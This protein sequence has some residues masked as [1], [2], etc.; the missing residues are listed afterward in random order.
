MMGRAMNGASTP[1]AQTPA[2]QTPAAS[3]PALWPDPDL[4]KAARVHEVTGGARRPFALALAGRLGCPVIWIQDAR[5]RALLYAP[6]IAA[7]MDPAQII[8]TRPTGA[9]PMLQAAEEALRSG[10]AALV[11]V[12]LAEAP[13]LT[14]SRRLQLA[15]GTGGGRGLCLVPEG[16]LRTN[17][18]ETRWCCQPVPDTRAGLGSQHWEIVKNK[19]GRLGHW[20]VGWDAARGGFVQTCPVRES[21]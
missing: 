8:L 9:I 11:V 3:V 19:R 16:T 21:V 5:S 6:G 2:A 13:D 1:A 7:L 15:A 4:L 20:R 17:A 14:Q 12:E 18:A 10:A